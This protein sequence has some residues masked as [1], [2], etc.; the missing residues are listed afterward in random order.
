MSRYW[1]SVAALS[2]GGMYVAANV[3]AFTQAG[4]WINLLFPLGAVAVNQSAMTLF[5]YLTEARQK[6][7]IRQAFQYYL[8]PAI[9]ERVAQNPQLLKLAVK[10]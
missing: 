1:G 6:R 10:P 4:L 5:N 3:L 2:L 9:V 8:H 7:L